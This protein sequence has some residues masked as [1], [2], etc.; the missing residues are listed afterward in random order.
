MGRRLIVSSLVQDFGRRCFPRARNGFER[1]RSGLVHSQACFS[2]CI[3]RMVS[4][5][6]WQKLVYFGHGKEIGFV[7]AG[8]ICVG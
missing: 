1:A 8:P 2:R 7:A 3:L 5:K 6:V 4:I